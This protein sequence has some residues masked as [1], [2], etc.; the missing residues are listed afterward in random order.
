MYWPDSAAQALL[1]FQVL[2]QLG[3]D[4][5]LVVAT[6]GSFIPE[7][8]RTGW[9]LLILANGRTIADGYGCHN[10][11]TCTCMKLEAIQRALNQ[12]SQ[13]AVDQQMVIFATD[14]M[15]VLAVQAGCWTS[16]CSIPAYV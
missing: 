15:A 12:L 6:D 8:D 3:G 14:S 4:D 7:I 5:A 2:L 11:Y 1:C 16:E 10:V 9:G 13:S